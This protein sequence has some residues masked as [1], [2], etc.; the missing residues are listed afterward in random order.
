MTTLTDYREA[1]V[2]LVPGSH[3]LDASDL[4]DAQTK[5]VAKAMDA[6]S[7]HRPVTVVEDVAGDGGFDYALADLEDWADGFSVVREV[8]YPVDDTNETPDIL[9]GADWTI[10]AKPSGEVLRFLNDKPSTDES[11]RVTY[12]ARHSCNDEGC[13][14]KAGDEEAV[15]S[16]AA[17]FYCKI[18]AA[19]YALDVDSTIAAD[20][21]N[22]G[23]RHAAFLKLA[24]QYRGEYNDHM[25]IQAGKPKPA[26]AI[27]DQDVTYP[28]GA[29][30]LTHPGRYR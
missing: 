28:G 22:Q 30:R 23:P 24:D 21:V 10:Y 12:T 19:A 16:L 9:D 2:D 1:I 11:L 8:E 3:P 26:V 7:K 25:G 27:G 5:A 15:Q 4:V 6:H 18:L 29:D 14:V 13:T 17:S 20:T